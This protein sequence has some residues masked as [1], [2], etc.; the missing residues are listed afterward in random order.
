MKISRREMPR[1]ESTDFLPPVILPSFLPHLFVHD[2]IARNEMQQGTREFQKIDFQGEFPR[3]MGDR[4]HG[5]ILYSYN[6]IARLDLWNRE[7]SVTQPGWPEDN[8]GNFLD[9]RIIDHRG[10]W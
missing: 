1:D 3:S 4:N 8:R 10:S 6:L 2:G 7:T 9:S 5:R